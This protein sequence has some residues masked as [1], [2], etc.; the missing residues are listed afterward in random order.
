[1]ELRQSERLILPA[2]V[3]A[4]FLSVS[5]MHKRIA[6]RRDPAYPAART[7]QDQSLR[8]EIARRLPKY[9]CGISNL[10]RQQ[11]FPARHAFRGSA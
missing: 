9:A 10:Q 5:P 6:Q 4:L 2:I 7:G 8:P 11:N 3:V 1:M